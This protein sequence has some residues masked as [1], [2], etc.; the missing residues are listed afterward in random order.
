[1]AGGIS[2]INFLHKFPIYIAIVF[3]FY[4]FFYLFLIYFFFTFLFYF[5]YFYLFFL[6]IFLF[7]YFLFFIFY[8]SIDFFCLF[9][10]FFFFVLFSNYFSQIN[11]EFYIYRPLNINLCA[12]QW[13]EKKKNKSR[14][15]TGKINKILMPV[16]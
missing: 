13:N 15:R 8:F 4:C 12:F 2:L 16:E 1:M 5:L 3:N 11:N 14:E 9:F 6:F 10:N 7:F